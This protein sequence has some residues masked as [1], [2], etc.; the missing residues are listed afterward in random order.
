AVVDRGVGRGIDV[1]GPTGVEHERG[2]KVSAAQTERVADAA[3][4]GGAVVGGDGPAV[5]D[6]R[7]DVRAAGGVGDD[8]VTGVEDG[9][10]IGDVGERKGVG[11]VLDDGAGDATDRAGP[12]LTVAGGEGA[13]GG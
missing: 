6:A 10:A 8:G 2:G 9:V 4:K 11:P 5:R 7:V 12:S 1:N 13:G 3:G